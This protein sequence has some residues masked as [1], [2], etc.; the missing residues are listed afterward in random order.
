MF[1]N[2]IE[3]PELDEL[4]AMPIAGFEHFDEFE[5]RGEAGVQ[6]SWTRRVKLVDRTPYI[7]MLGKYLNAFP[8][9][10]RPTVLPPT[11]PRH[12]LSKLT[13]DEWEQYQRCKEP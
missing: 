5:E 13:A 6:T 3:I 9:T 2:P 1:G 11:Q 12:D 7:L 8:M 10:K 4:H